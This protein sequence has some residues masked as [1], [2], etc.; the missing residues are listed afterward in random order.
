V[1]YSMWGDATTNATS[2]AFLRAGVI[3]YANAVTAA[4]NV[5]VSG[6]A[7]STTKGVGVVGNGGYAGG[8]FT[9]TS[10]TGYGLIARNEDGGFAL[11]TNGPSSLQGNVSV[12]GTI[13]A[14]G[15]ITAY[16]DL[17]LKQDLQTIGSALDKVRQLT[18]YT[19]TRKDTGERQTGLVAQDVQ[20]VLPEAVNEGE[21]LSVAY[22]NLIGLLVE[23]IK[24]LDRKVNP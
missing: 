9:S 15:N 2:A 16:S 17:R 13:T 5:G 6:S 24:E 22:G 18:G 11:A 12:T 19:F 10:A 14:T 8:F 20:A 21:Y 4:W 7:P 23:A 1:D 3:G